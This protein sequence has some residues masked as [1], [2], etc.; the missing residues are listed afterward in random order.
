[1][2]E[3]RRPR[4]DLPVLSAEARG[5]RRLPLLEESREVDRRHRP[6]VAVWELT[7]RCDLACKHC[8]SRA[9]RARPD[10]LDLAQCLDL[11]DQLSELEV[12]EVSLIGG[13]AYLRDG[14]LEIVRALRDRDIDASIVTG[15]RGWSRA[16]AREAADAGLQSVSVSLDGDEA[17]HDR[18]RGVKGA[19]RSALAALQSTREAGM[20]A[21]VNTQINRIS[22]SSLDD[23]IEQMTEIGAAAWQFMLTVAMGRAAD[24]PELLLQPHDLLELFPR[25]ALMAERCREAG[26]EPFAGNN[27]G[28]FGPHDA[29]FRG[30][31]PGGHSGQCG[32][33][34]GT[35]GIEADGSIKGCPSLPSEAWVGGNVRDDRLVTI[36]ERAEPLRYT[37][38][39]GVAD[40]WGYCR[41]CY[42]AENCMAGCTWTGFS[43]FGKPGNNPYCHHRALEFAAKG[44]RERVVRVS[45]AEGVP[46]DHGIFEIV[47]ESTT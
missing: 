46:F 38:D 27:I 9:A 43:L 2:T 14:W 34:R 32:A 22:E 6:R 20:Q 44:L 30:R 28:Y 7:L 21:T 23:V 1:M 4:R 5:K 31:M 16:L 12:L 17:S 40:L 39:R 41:E 35:L 42:Y 24:Q 29:T 33:G 26:V 15:G 36:W 13:E 37:R 19:H 3:L 8:G 45:S 18:L 47:V 10:E 25:L 11:V